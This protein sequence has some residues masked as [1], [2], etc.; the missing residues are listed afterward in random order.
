MKVKTKYRTRG[1]AKLPTF[2]NHYIFFGTETISFSPRTIQRMHY[3]R[4]PKPRVNGSDGKGAVM[5]NVRA[6]QDI[7]KVI[8]KEYATNNAHWEKTYFPNPLGNCWVCT[9]NV[10]NPNNYLGLIIF[11]LHSQ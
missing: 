1:V 3:T 4:L 2:S 11:Q 7:F 6:E 9:G 10:L 5:Q 8:Q